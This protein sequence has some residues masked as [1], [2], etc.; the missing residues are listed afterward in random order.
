MAIET[1]GSMSVNGYDSLKNSIPTALGQLTNNVGYITAAEVNIPDASQSTKGIATLGAT[2]GAARFGQKADVGLSKVNDTT[3]MEKPVSTL[4]Q[5][6]L[7]KISTAIPSPS[8][9]VPLMDGAASVGSSTNY[10]RADHRHP[11]DSGKVS[12]VSTTNAVYVTGSTGDDTTIPF[13]STATANSIPRRDTSGNLAVPTTVTG[14]NAIGASQ[15]DS[16]VTAAVTGL[17][18]DSTVVHK[19]GAETVA[20]IK[21]FSSIPVL[22]ASNPT[23]DNQAVRKAYADTK[24]SKVSSAS[25]FARV[26]AISSDGTARMYPISSSDTTNETLMLRNGTT[27]FS[28]VPANVTGNNAIGASQV[29]SKISTA[30]ANKVD[31]SAYANVV[32]ATGDT[33][34]VGN[35]IPYSVEAIANYI[36]RRSGSGNVAVPASVTGN[37]A[38]GASQVDSK[39]TSAA[40][41]KVDKITSSGTFPKL[42]GVGTDGSQTTY[43]LSSSDVSNGTLMLRNA[44]TGFSAVPATVTGNNAIGAT[45]VNNERVRKYNLP[46]P[47]TTGTFVYALG[48]IASGIGRTTVSGTLRIERGGA[49]PLALLVEIVAASAGTT[50]QK[51]KVRYVYSVPSG[52]TAPAMT[53][54]TFTYNS[55]NYMGIS[56]T[57][58]GLYN[59]ITFDGAYTGSFNSG[60]P[61]SWSVLN[62]TAVSG[63]TV[64]SEEDD[65]DAKIA[66]K[67]DELN[68]PDVVYATRESGNT[69][70]IRYGVLPMDS[71]IVQ[72]QESGNITVP[73]NVPSQTSHAV[74]MMQVE[75]MIAESTGTQYVT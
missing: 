18:P 3:D 30:G 56:M 28:A 34:G 54:V 7:D 57:Q 43:P 40:A 38:I 22:P 50:T 21:T 58:L 1:D 71:Y 47:S 55:R 12:S 20:G 35:N 4:Q 53:V 31:K 19:S 49:N 59:S 15:V 52:A 29:D 61:T 13:S 48:E 5:A 25:T 68:V 75:Q 60:G 46:I 17:A 44:T 64:I 32:Y 66:N 8:A 51:A 16:K 36:P 72:R 70:G 42:Y 9:T 67:V 2:G 33:A 27:G 62:S 39:I 37:N 45:Q 6:A 74:G 41:N 10:A 65:I 11:S 14:N 73:D 23:S 26:Y 24:V 63:I 69:Y